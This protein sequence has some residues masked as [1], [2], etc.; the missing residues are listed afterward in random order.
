MATANLDATE[1]FTT[2]GGR[3]ALLRDVYRQTTLDTLQTGPG[4]S[5]GSGLGRRRCD[6]S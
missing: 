2:G 1:G 3:P 5:L 6:R 4:A